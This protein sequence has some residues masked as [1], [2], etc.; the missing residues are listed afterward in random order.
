MTS[1]FTIKGSQTS[2]TKFDLTGYLNGEILHR[3][4]I[5]PRVVGHRNR[6]I[7]EVTRRHSE[8]EPEDIEKLLLDFLDSNEIKDGASSISDA[9]VE[10]YLLQ[11]E[12][13]LGRIVRPDLIMIEDFSAIAV[14]RIVEVDSLLKP[15]WVLYIN[16]SGRRSVKAVQ[17]SR[18]KIPDQ[19]ELYLSP[20]LVAPTPAEVSELCRW[21]EASRRSWVEGRQVIGTGDLLDRLVNRIDRFVYLDPTHRDFILYSLASWV[22]MT[23]TCRALPAVPYLYLGGPANSGKT[24]VMNVLASLAYRPIMTSSMRGATLFRTMHLNGGTLFLDEAEQLKSQNPE[25]DALTQ[26]LQAGY[27]AGATAT[28]CEGD[29]HRPVAFQV[30]GPKVLGCI[31]G[32]PPALLSRCIEIQMRRA[33]KGEKRAMNVLD[34][35]EPEHI[36]LVDSLHEW[37]LE[38]GFQAMEQEIPSN[39]L[40]NRDAELWR[41][42]LSIMQHTGSDEIVSEILKYAERKILEASTSRSSESDCAAIQALYTLRLTGHFPTC[43]EVLTEM[44]SRELGFFDSLTARGVSS[45]LAN[46]GFK[47][48]S[49]NGRKCIKTELDEI[50]KVAALYDFELEVCSARSDPRAGPI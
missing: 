43:A 13:S 9:G 47:T 32:L 10:N 49:S 26:I 40:A 23:Y 35:K 42:L 19:G 18:L 4:V 44:Q 41:P 16:Q 25:A 27:K 6:F 30:Y 31:R 45:V 8:L 34:M 39:D 21:T 37:A 50:E 14:P 15:H 20:E 46:Y 1:G 17:A 48:K 29:L 33:P 11:D 3:D 28:R 12:I 7:D 36:A 22:M 38:Y 5:D 24:T 2:P